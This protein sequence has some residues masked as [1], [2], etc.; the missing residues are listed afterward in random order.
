[1]PHLLG[2]HPANSLVVLGIG[3]PHGRIRLAFRYDLPDPPDSALSADVAAHATAVLGREHLTLAVIVGYG[4]GQ[5]V[6]SLVD[7]VAPALHEAR[8]AVQDVLRV[9]EGRYWSYLCADPHCCPPE[10]SPYDPANHPAAEALSA[11]GFTARSSRA[12]LAGTLARD[13]G[14]IEPMAAAVERARDRVA[15]LI[16]DLLREPAGGDPLQVIADAGRRHIRQAVARY[17]RGGAVTDF[18]ELAWLG[19]TLTDLRVR[20]DAWARMDPAFNDA[21]QRLWTDLIR[22]LPAEFV[23]APASL[24][25][26]TAWQ[27]GDGALAAIAIER[28]LTADPEYSMAK[29][30]ADA[31]H[32]GLPP[33]AA[34][35]PMTPKQVAASYA[36]HRK[37]TQ[38]RRRR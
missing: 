26:F 16:N 31:L 19:L 36:R 13:P 9:H 29:L 5:A 35:L 34:R 1:V 28:A 21:H 32:A 37:P 20:D 4:P 25:A 17:R 30:I 10:G 18:E 11:A 7:A 2:F 27:S 15:Q 38:P 6:T 12:A 22:Q 23:A 24:L 33:S 8:I 14:S 3:G